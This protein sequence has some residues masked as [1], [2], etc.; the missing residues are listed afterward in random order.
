MMA[1]TL[2]SAG[3]ALGLGDIHVDSALNEPLAAEIDIVGATPED[4]IGLIAT[5]A[6]RE[7]FAHFNAERP[8]FLNSATFKVTTDAK[9]KP[10]LAI[11]SSESFSEP[12]IDLVVDLRWRNG[13]LIRQYSLLLDPAGFPAAP[14]AAAALPV[15]P[16]QAALPQAVITA[17]SS[18]AS[19]P[20][21][22]SNNSSADTV[23]APVAHGSAAGSASTQVSTR[24]AMTQIKVGARATLRG[25]AWRVGARSGGDINQMMIAIFRA[26][27]SAFDGNINRLHLGATLRIPSAEEV[28]AIS[29]AE[30]NRETHA[31]MQA[32]LSSVKRPGSNPV[33]A[34]AQAAPAAAP[35]ASNA[36]AT[37]PAAGAATH[38]NNSYAATIPPQSAAPALTTVPALT[39]AP[40]RS[41]AAQTSAPVQPS[42]PVQAAAPAQSAPAEAAASG[43]PAK[44]GDAASEK[45]ALTT[46]LLSLEG[47]LHELQAQ[48]EAQHNS[49]LTMQAQ[50]RYAE[51]HPQVIAAAPA[52]SSGRG[53]LTAA[54]AGMAVLAAACVA[55]LMRLRR[56]ANPSYLPSI[57]K[58]PVTAQLEVEP[59]APRVK[60][61]APVRAPEAARIEVQE[62]HEAQSEPSA[63]ARV[64][65]Y[66]QRAETQE[67]PI[68]SALE[69]S[70][71]D[72]SGINAAKLREELAA[73]KLR[74]EIAAAWA[75]PAA[76][77]YKREDLDHDSTLA[78]DI[79][80]SLEDTVNLAKGNVSADDTIEEAYTDTI[81][82]SHVD[83]FVE[84]TAETGNY[85][86]A[87]ALMP[88][89]DSEPEAIQIDADNLDYNLL[90]LD[91]PDAHVNMEGT[92]QEQAVVKDRRTS[93][94]DVLKQAIEREP[95]RRD[96]RIKLLE[97]YYAEAAT[98][99]ES[100]LEAMQSLE[101]GD[102]DEAEWQKIE[103]MGAQLGT[104]SSKLGADNPKLG[105][106]SLKLGA[107]SPE[108]TSAQDDNFLRA[109]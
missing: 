90:D 24:A 55:L 45:A 27:P 67:D 92:T 36:V 78:M 70:I 28:G 68:E 42:A 14:Q 84:A 64:G 69:L 23:P 29:H 80:K 100:F 81:V 39:T 58:V 52:Q 85:E 15:P 21:E 9:G 94:V 18:P 66:A 87:T 96:L 37:T 97:T 71:G 107:D 30:A 105:T 73:A 26:N 17:A 22:P 77:T 50:L 86:A 103:Q 32:W 35:A 60:P 104:D 54:L 7:T 1:C 48:L 43:P 8:S 51:Q 99:R 62:H 102:M 10:V 83:T 38:S 16:T 65:T 41:A 4:L 46:Q 44:P 47:N 31:Q 89:P 49:L 109:S 106:D 5:V 57:E 53:L 79:A 25:V 91:G 2:P 13:Q 108:L 95:H 88:A 34:V 82:N 3:H 6:N 76:E 12:L 19:S 61:T 72:T 75:L 20:A 93:V 11:R 74:E 40:A 101:R 63:D 33:S 56:R 59:P 98:N